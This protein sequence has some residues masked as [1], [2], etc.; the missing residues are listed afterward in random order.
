[1]NF[2]QLI[3]LIASS[4]LLSFCDVKSLSYPNWLLFIFI[5]L[6]LL[7]HPI[8]FWGFVVFGLLGV[9]CLIFDIGFGEGDCFLLGIWCFWLSIHE[10][11]LVLF[12][13]SGT[14]LLFQVGIFLFYRQIKQPLPFIPFLTIGLITTI[15]CQADLLDKIF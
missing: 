13:A 6:S 11:A 12:I 2:I 10:L 15:C 14:A 3:F 9:C 8:H 7:L 1:M 4:L 5:G